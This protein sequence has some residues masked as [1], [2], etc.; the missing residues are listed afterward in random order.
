MTHGRPDAR[1]DRDD[2]DA[3]GDDHLCAGPAP[4]R[5]LHDREGEGADTD[6]EECPAD[7]IGKAAVL[8]VT[9]VG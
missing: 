5:P 6:E 8:V 2:R 4:V 1:E 9:G 7:Q 3:E